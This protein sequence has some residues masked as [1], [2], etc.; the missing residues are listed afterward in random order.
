MEGKLDV[1]PLLPQEVPVA[2]AVLTGL[3]AS[4]GWL[5]AHRSARGKREAQRSPAITDPHNPSHPQLSS[6]WMGTERRAGETGSARGGVGCGGWTGQQGGDMVRTAL[7][8][9]VPGSLQ[10]FSLFL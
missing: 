4:L 7:R 10:W 5:A 9:R 6:L 2:V 3:L 8:F 1:Y